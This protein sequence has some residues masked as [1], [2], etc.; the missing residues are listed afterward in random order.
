MRNRPTVTQEDYYKLMVELFNTPNGKA[1]LEIWE[2]QFLFK[3]VAIHG[4]DLLT[5]GLKQGEAS[6]VLSIINLLEQEDQI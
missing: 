5:I 3:K 2:D 4:D 1:L 6:F